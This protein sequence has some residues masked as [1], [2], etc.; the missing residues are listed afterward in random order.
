M[1]KYDVDW[2]LQSI[3]QGKDLEYLFFWGHRPSKD[4][5]IGPSCLSQ[6]W[7]SSFSVAGVTY[8]SA[9]HWMMASKARMFKDDEMLERILKASSAAKAEK[10]GRLIYNVDEVFWAEQRYELAKE[11]AYH[12]FVQAPK[13]KAYLLSTGDKILAESSP[14]D[15]TWGIGITRD[16]KNAPYPGLW[17]GKGL[18]GFAL[19]EVRDL[20]REDRYYE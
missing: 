1:A 10:L 9:E 16:H 7:P 19:M 18:L 20:I 6:W 8:K 14:L 12:K 11:G 17:P 5:K 4:G 13:L 15:N 3:E 2:L